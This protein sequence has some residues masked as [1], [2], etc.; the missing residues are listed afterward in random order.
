MF[1]IWMSGMLHRIIMIVA[2]GAAYQKKLSFALRGQ[3]L[4]TYDGSKL[5]LNIQEEPL[6]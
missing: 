6:V 5:K 4:V 3:Q 1:S 2:G